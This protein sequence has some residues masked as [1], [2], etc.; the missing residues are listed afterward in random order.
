MRTQRQC[1][2]TEKHCG[3]GGVAGFQRPVRLRRIAQGE[4]LIDG[5]CR[6]ARPDGVKKIV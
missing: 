4:S 2:A 5:D 1:S 3:A 6:F